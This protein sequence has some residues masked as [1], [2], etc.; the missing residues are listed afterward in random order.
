VCPVEIQLYV[1]VFNDELGADEESTLHCTEAV[2]VRQG[3]AVSATALFATAPP[4][5]SRYN[6]V[7]DFVLAWVRRY[8]RCHGCAT[9]GRQSMVER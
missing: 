3:N 6:V 7:V 4:K 9:G 5:G 1:E 8:S 2:A